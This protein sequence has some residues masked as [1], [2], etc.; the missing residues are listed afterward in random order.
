MLLLLSTG[1]IY[2]LFYAVSATLSSLFS[3]AYPNLNETEVGLCFLSIGGAGALATIVQGRVLDWQFRS[4]KKKWEADRKADK[5]KHGNEKRVKGSEIDDEDRGGA[6]ARDDFPIEKATLQTQFIW[7]LLMS[8]SSVGY[9]WS[10]QKRANIAVPLVMQ[11]ISEYPSVAARLEGR[12]AHSLFFSWV[13]A[14]RDPNK[15]ADAH[16]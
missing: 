15:Y 6:H 2:C 4:V 3:A 5:E 14:R 10:I 9:G 8:A 16:R 12:I 7:I 13:Y 11:F 1:I